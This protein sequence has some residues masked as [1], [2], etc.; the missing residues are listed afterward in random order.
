MKFPRLVLVSALFVSLSVVSSESS[1]AKL[2]C[3]IV[4]QQTKKLFEGDYKGDPEKALVAFA[5]LIVKA[6][7][8]T[9][10]NASC[11]KK[12]EISDLKL[13]IK[14]LK[15]DCESARNSEASWISQKEICSVYKPLWKY[16]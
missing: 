13:Q 1:D 16:I 3:A 11:F 8:L 6:Y 12:K 9:L 14:K 5:G 4:K 10:D 2:S 7:R 15:A